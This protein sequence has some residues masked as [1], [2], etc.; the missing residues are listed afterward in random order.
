MS[1][2]MGLVEFGAT[3][4]ENRMAKMSPKDVDTL[5]FGAIQLDA[6]GNILKYNAMEGQI[7]GRD[8]AT[9]IGKNFFTEVAPCTNTPTFKGEFTKGVLAGNLNTMFAYTFDYDMKPTKVKVHMKK[10]VGD[11][12]YWIFVKRL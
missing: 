2:I 8:P 9:M 1:A 10:A 12:T 6:K 4:V 3:D 11:A 7:T 5:A